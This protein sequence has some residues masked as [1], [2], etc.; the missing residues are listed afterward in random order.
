MLMHRQAPIALGAL[1]ACAAAASA[2]LLLRQQILHFSSG[3]HADGGALSPQLAIPQVR[4]LRP[5][6]APLTHSRQAR[7]TV[8]RTGA[9]SA[10]PALGAGGALRLAAP[11]ALPAASGMAP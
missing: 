11:F 2:S 4:E 5:G 3:Q 1:V 6:P 10:A 7:L 8:T 9:A